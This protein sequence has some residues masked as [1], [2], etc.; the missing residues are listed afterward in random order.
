MKIKS[1]SCNYRDRSYPHG[2][3]I[4]AEGKLLDCVDGNWVAVVL[5]SGI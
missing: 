2:S 3:E 1:R 4:S 5:V